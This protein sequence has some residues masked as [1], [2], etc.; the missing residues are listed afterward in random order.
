[1]HR[2]LANS[3]ERCNYE[4]GK[5]FGSEAEQVDDDDDEV[6]C[7]LHVDDEDFDLHAEHV[8]EQTC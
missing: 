7:V 1:M 2:D 3:A 4:L 5:S 6:R 8:I